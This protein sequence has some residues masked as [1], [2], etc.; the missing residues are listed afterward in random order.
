MSLRLK[1]LLQLM[2]WVVPLTVMPADKM[3]FETVDVGDVL[4]GDNVLSMT[5]LPDGRMA[6][7]TKSGTGIYD[8]VRMSYVKH[9]PSCESGLELY[10]GYMHPYVDGDTLLWIKNRGRVWAIDLRRESEIP[11]PQ[12]IVSSRMGGVA[13][14]LFGDGNRLWFVDIGNRLVDPSGVVRYEWSS[15]VRLQ[16]LMTRGDTIDLFT[17]D[18]HVLGMNMHDW[19]VCYD[20]A[21]MAPEESASLSGTSLVVRGS[22]GAYYQLRTGSHGALLRFDPATRRWSRLLCTEYPLFVLTQGHGDICY[23]SCPKGLWLIDMHRLDSPRHLPVLHTRSGRILATQVIT[24]HADSQGGL[25]LGS[26]SRGVLYHHPD[27]FEVSDIDIGDLP[28]GLATHR[29]TIRFVEDSGGNVYVASPD[30]SMWRHNKSGRLEHVATNP[31]VMETALFGAEIITG[32]GA[33]Y[34]RDE[35]GCTLFTPR[36]DTIPAVKPP[37]V[38]RMWVGGEEILPATVLDHCKVIDVS[39][40]YV[41][42]VVLPYDHNFIS[43][44][45]VTLNYASPSSDMV[46]YM[47]EGLDTDWNRALPTADRGGIHYDMSYRAIA[48]GKYNLRVRT[49]GGESELS[50][51]ITPPW[52][53]TTWAIMIWVFIG[54]ATV[55]AG[56]TLFLVVSRRRMRRRHREELLLARIRALIEQRD[57]YEEEKAAQADSRQSDQINEATEKVLPQRD[58]EFIDRAI[59]MVEQHMDDSSYTVERLSRDLAI[60]RSGLYRKLMAG[61]DQSPR[62]FMRTV[63]L[64]RASRL[65]AEGHYTVTEIADLTGF[66]SVSYFSRCFQDM[67]GA[68]PTEY[69]IKTRSGGV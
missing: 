14:D 38:T 4:Q 65:L 9:D 19:K 13:G 25:W 61:L 10:D 11:D 51:I 49:S 41:R 56:I 58:R 63:R 5:E 53:L 35:N 54:V 34:F 22:D 17:S 27:R 57:A 62:M 67:Y 69:A 26:S 44:E 33:L 7:V 46:Y 16:D 31:N 12:R 50:V 59:R 30:G 2:V 66:S 48:P 36:H 40:P 37:L 47:L 39:M 6:F 55:V 42:E 68:T 28:H 43:F 52:W 15:G 18:G 1:I 45:A 23:V 21:S 64:Q 60:D 24:I 20:V 3:L 8:G 32:S 29:N